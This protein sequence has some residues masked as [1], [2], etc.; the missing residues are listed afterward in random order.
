MLEFRN[1]LQEECVLFI[2]PDSKLFSVTV[3]QF[4]GKYLFKGLWLRSTW[5]ESQ[6]VEK[7]LPLMC[8]LIL[9]RSDRNG[10]SSTFH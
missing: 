4:R 3:P 7:L 1:F 6:N 8:Y 5:K 10:S 2:S 9:G